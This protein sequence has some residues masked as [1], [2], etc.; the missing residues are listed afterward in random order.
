LLA[1]LQKEK[2]PELTHYLAQPKTIALLRANQ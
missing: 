1:A 2:F